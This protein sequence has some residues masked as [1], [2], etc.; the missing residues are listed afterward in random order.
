MAYINHNDLAVLDESGKANMR[1]VQ[2]G[3]E[4]NSFDLFHDLA[5]ADS[6]GT[7]RNRD[8]DIASSPMPSSSR[9]RLQHAPSIGQADRSSAPTDTVQ[10]SSFGS[11]PYL[12]VP[13]KRQNSDQAPKPYA[14][15]TLHY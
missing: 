4:F 7:T 13:P 8:N 10:D 15:A 14:I 1:P 12:C 11:T 5:M 3:P 2:G 6:G 9:D